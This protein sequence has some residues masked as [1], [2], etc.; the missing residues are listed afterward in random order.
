MR[1][2]GRPSVSILMVCTA[3]ICR[4]PMA[5]A[6]LRKELKLR[7]MSRKVS[8]ESAG[9]AALLGYRTD[10]RAQQV[11]GREGIN[12]RKSRA[13]QVIGDDFLR[14]DYILAMDQRNHQWL[15]DSCPHSHRGR[16]SCLGSWAVGGPIGDIPDPYFSSL[17]GFEQVLLKLHLC[18]DGFLAYFLEELKRIGE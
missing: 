6:L 5:A 15:L 1:F 18:I 17:V 16:I 9:T 2:F 3:N 8:V 12:L 13:R 11:C 14:F 7:G 10:G 4:S